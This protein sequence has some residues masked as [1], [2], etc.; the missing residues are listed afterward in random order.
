MRKFYGLIIA[1]TLALT[2]MAAPASLEPPK[3]PKIKASE[4]FVPVG[5]TGMKI[6]LQDLS[7][8]KIKDLETLTGQKLS[9]SE[10]IGL[11]AAQ[12]Q[13]S[14][15]I[16]RDGTLNSKKMNKWASRSGETGFHLGGFALGFLL[17]LIGVLIAYIISDD[18]KSNRRKWAWIGWGTFV[19]IY[20]VAL[21]ATMG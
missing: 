20:L 16:N 4:V 9:L 3:S 17:G 13:L 6:S 18:Y 5:K 19:V 8:M 15:S 7:V 12:K 10:K 14:Q 21:I 11:K 1:L 2:G